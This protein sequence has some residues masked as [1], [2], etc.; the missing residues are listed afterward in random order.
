MCRRVLFTGTCTRCAHF[1]TWTDLTQELSCLESKNVG[2]FGMCRHGIQ[3]ESHSFD[4]ECDP[5]A[6]VS[7][8]DEGVDIFD[9]LPPIEQAQPA[10]DHHK[11]H[12]GKGKGKSPIRDAEEGS[13]KRKK[14]RTA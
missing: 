2:Q 6:A 13:R 5:C 12:K 9:E 7:N 14:Q 11:R 10:P 8:E 3:E 4:Q 1:F